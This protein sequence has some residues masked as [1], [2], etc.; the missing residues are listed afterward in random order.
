MSEPGAIPGSF[1]IRSTTS[2]RC[3]SGSLYESQSYRERIS[4]GGGGSTSC[5][6][7][8][9]G[10]TASRSRYL[11]STSVREVGQRFVSR[12]EPKSTSGSSFPVP[13]YLQPAELQVSDLPLSAMVDKSTGPTRRRN[14]RSCAV[15]RLTGHRNPPGRFPFP[16]RK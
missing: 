5:D 8:L 10:Q 4:A 1:R 9:L 16:S 6:P 2:S 14:S 7:P 11:Y 13:Q 15:Y 12:C 3:P